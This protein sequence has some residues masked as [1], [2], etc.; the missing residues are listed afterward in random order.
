MYAHSER[1]AAWELCAGDKLTVLDTA[2]GDTVVG[3]T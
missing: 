3:T 1:Q 2:M